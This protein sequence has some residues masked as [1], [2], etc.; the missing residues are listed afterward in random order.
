LWEKVEKTPTC[1]LYH[2]WRNNK[3]YGMIGD[4]AGGHR[5]RHQLAHRIAYEL[6]V[7]V[8][9]DGKNVL[10]HCDV[11]LCVNP[12]HLY[13]G[14]QKENVRDMITRGRRKEY[15]RRG[16]RNPATQLTD[17]Q[18]STI[19]RLAADGISPVVLARRFGLKHRN[20][21]YDILHRRTFAHVP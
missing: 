17:V 1:W 7:G 9:P 13:I 15:D 16:E 11:P 6:T 5:Y 20:R 14:T 19:R 10:H 8:I 3:G 21:V 18:A 2:G 4:A 12:A